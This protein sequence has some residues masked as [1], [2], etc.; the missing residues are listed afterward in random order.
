MQKHRKT[1][2]TKKAKIKDLPD[3]IASL[4]HDMGSN[5]QE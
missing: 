1:A 5:S 2:K 4:L 3:V